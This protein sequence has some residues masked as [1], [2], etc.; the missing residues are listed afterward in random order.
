MTNP[1]LNLPILSEYN[2]ITRD[3]WER[4]LNIAGDLC[5]HKQEL[6]M[7]THQNSGE[8]REKLIS[9]KEASHKTTSIRIKRGKEKLSPNNLDLE[10]RYQF[11]R[12]RI[13]YNL[14]TSNLNIKQSLD[15]VKLKLQNW[16]E[17]EVS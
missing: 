7:R 5:T 1:I 11:W 8:L 2:R 3:L 14:F 6:Q 10:K 15:K 16:A 4:T 17:K 12:I 13:N 9:G